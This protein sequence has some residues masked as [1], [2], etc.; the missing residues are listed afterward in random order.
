MARPKLRPPLVQLM[1]RGRAVGEPVS[2]LMVAGT[3]GT[4]VLVVENLETLS[5]TGEG[6]EG[7]DSACFLDAETHEPLHRFAIRLVS[8]DPAGTLQFVPGALV[9]TIGSLSSDGGPSPN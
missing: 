7:A 2:A 6:V 3:D 9:M 8:E 1:R 5:F 4:G